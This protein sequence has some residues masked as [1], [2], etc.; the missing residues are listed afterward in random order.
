MNYLTILLIKKSNFF[1][2]KDWLNAKPVVFFIKSLTVLTICTNS[3]LSTEILNPKICSLTLIKTSRLLILASATHTLKFRNKTKK[4]RIHYHKEDLKIVTI[5]KLCN[6]WKPHV[7]A[8]VMQPHKWLRGKSTMDSKLICGALGS[9][10][11][12]WFVELCRFKILI[13]QLSI[14][15][16][17]L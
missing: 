8:H 15:K 14:K 12:P 6:N 2:N 7:A 4:D 17:S 10:Y 16:Y 13:P 5:I 9:F 1:F 3:R 11:L